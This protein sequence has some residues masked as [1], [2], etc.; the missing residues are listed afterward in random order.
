MKTV[1]N[2]NNE[3]EWWLDQIKGENLNKFMTIKIR[4]T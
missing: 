1:E 3:K 2:E 4:N